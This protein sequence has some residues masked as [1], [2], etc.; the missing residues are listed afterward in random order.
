[1]EEISK[2]LVEVDE[3]LNHLTNENYLKIPKNIIQVIKD[4]KDKHYVWKYDNTKKFENQNLN[5]DTL[6]L[7]AYINTEYLLSDEQKQIMIQYYKLNQQR[8]EKAKK[9]KYNSF[10][11]SKKSNDNHIN[12]EKAPNMPTVKNEDNFL[13]KILKRFFKALKK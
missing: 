2:R 12:D 11:I 9:G 5:S 4:N 7:L 13:S 8:H 1:M 3:I 6:A 10:E